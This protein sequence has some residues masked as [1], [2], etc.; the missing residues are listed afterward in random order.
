M[1]F[2]DTQICWKYFST[3]S[4]IDNN[5]GGNW[6]GMMEKM[7]ERALQWF[8]INLLTHK[9]QKKGNVSGTAVI[10]SDYLQI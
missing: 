6:I 5:I 10:V 1:F 4:R 9:F 8:S 3:D 7:D 2:E